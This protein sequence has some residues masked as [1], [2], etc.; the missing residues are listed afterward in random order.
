MNTFLIVSET[1]YQMDKTL[2][3]LKNGITNVITFNLNENTLDDVLTEA[4]YFS[5]F[6][7]RKC[8]IAKN[9]NFFASTKGTETKK[10]KEQI[11]KLLKYL[12][13]ENKNTRIIFTLL[14]SADTKKS[15]YKKFEENNTLYTFKKMTKTDMKNELLKIVNE[16]GYKIDDK[17]LWYIINNS[18]NNFDLSYNELNKIMLYYGKKS[19][20][21]Y[22]DVI[23]LTSKSLEN[24]NFKLVDSIMSRN[25]EEALKCL[26]EM[27]VFKVEPSAII[28]LLGREF[29]LMLSSTLYEENKYSYQS[30]LKELHLAEWQ[31]QK[32]INNKRNFT[33]KEMEQELIKIS[34]LDYKLKSGLIDKDIVLITYILDLCL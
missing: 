6:D 5:M 26:D 13:N 22:E 3:S 14:G 1:I 23:K 30:I 2:E 19:N 31:F 7:E 28:S 29:K 21:L 18:L 4:S 27:K 8:I 9:A 33:K 20:I 11:D 15:I 10:N 25:L 32:V 12:E 17:S 24:N 34:D 16:K